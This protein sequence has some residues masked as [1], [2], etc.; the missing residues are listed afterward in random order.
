[1]VRE[2]AQKRLYPRCFMFIEDFRAL[3]GWKFILEDFENNLYY[4]QN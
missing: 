2:N 4:F 1:M 3:L